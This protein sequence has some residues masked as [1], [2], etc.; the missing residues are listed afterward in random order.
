MIFR[1]I[2]IVA[3]A[4]CAYTLAARV[5]A[6]AIVPADTMNYQAKLATL[7]PGDTLQL[8]AGTYSGLVLS[9]LNGTSSQ[10]IT[11]TGPAVDPPTAIIQ[12][13]A[14][15][16][17][18]VVEIKNSSFLAVV[19]LQ[20]DGNHVPG[21][22]G[23]ST[24][25]DMSNNVHDIRIED[26]L[27]VNCDKDTIDDDGQQDD[28]IS[29]KT[30]TWNWVIRHNQIVGAGTGMYLG[31]STG[32]DPFTGGLIENNLVVD[33]IGYCM[34]IKSQSTPRLSGAGQPTTPQTTVIR[35]N[36]WIKGDNACA[37][38]FCRPNVLVGGFPISGPGSED[39]YQIYGNFFYHNTSDQGLLQVSGRVTVHD[40]IMADAPGAWGIF[41][42]DDKGNF[43]PLEL[44]HAYNNTIYDVAQG[45][46][47]NNSAPEGDAVVGNLIFATKATV[48]PIMNQSD[49]LSDTVA[50]AVKYVSS[51][52]TTL[53]AMN[54][55]PLP[56][57]CTG[58]PIDESPFSTELA[59]DL[60]FNGMPK[61]TFTYRGA[62][63]GSGKNPGWPLG[64][65]FE[66]GGAGE[67]SSEAG[68]DSADGGQE[69]ASS[70][71]P[72]RADG[73]ADS[74]SSGDAPGNSPGTS[75]CGCN[76]AGTKGT[77]S[78]WLLAGACVAAV[79]GR[80]RRRPSGDVLGDTEGLDD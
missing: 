29:T 30:P 48:G 23:V 65:G 41:A 47:F 62:Y 17:C 45:I 56:G 31:N 19:S 25:G 5:S 42:S 70:R 37:A 67:A 63:A 26:C 10:W 1:R 34:E 4:V 75:G 22:F 35:N 54:F 68:T 58:T 74:G 43:A 53:G 27:I 80:R 38:D 20:I 14:S 44:V 51:P 64:D 73:E 49:N 78:V 8:A 55:Y 15:G 77:A 36:V 72:V 66:D 6:A 76:E 60:D 24:D 32:N 9:N 40:N 16:C 28:G 7:Q 71:S 12:A 52:G 33:P 3:S 57:E 18:N 59:Y 39:L 2:L 79:L 61:G 13:P 46:V 11:I 50:N 21:A 69:G